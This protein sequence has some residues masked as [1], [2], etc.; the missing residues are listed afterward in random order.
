M[1]WS[2]L[3]TGRSLLTNEHL[4]AVCTRMS[5]MTT[6][7]P[8]PLL[9][10]LLP[11]LLAALLLSACQRESMPIPSDVAVRIDGE[12]VAYPRFETYLRDN[13]DG[14]ELP[15]DSPLLSRLFDQFLDEEL[16]I[17]LAI[18]RGLA[19]ETPDPAQSSTPDVDPREAISFLL[20]K[21]GLQPA[22]DEEIEAW[23]HAQ[24]EQYQRPEGVR[25]RQIL[26]DEEDKAE[27]ALTAL[28]RKEDFAAVAA[29]FS[30]VPAAELGG[31]GGRLTREDLPP[32]FADEIFALEAGEISEIFN[33]DYGYHIFQVVEHFPAETVP[34]EEV[35][36]EI[37]ASLQRR[38]ID[39][40]IAS[41]IEEA[42]GRYAVE[43]YHS[44]V[45]FDYR[46]SYAN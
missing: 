20:R 30:Q 25:L 27:E 2:L 29:R 8:L 40:L 9:C 37:A 43:I 4:A 10:P 13:V 26:V 14:K 5:P 41:L 36:T 31:T 7:R 35:R 24:A 18:E 38:N 12:A 11:A 23:Y 19:I 1:L 33:A 21:I 28:R 32:A 45:P 39:E 44:N 6:R 16:L 17:R 15:S 3:H 46:G 42:R 22:T 34:L